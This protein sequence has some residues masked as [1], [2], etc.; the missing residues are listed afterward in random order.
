MPPSAFSPWQRLRS[1]AKPLTFAV[2]C[3]ANAE[4]RLKIRRGTLPHCVELA[5]IRCVN[6]KYQFPSARAYKRFQSVFL[7]KSQA[8]TYFAGINL[9]VS[10]RWICGFVHDAY[11]TSIA[12]VSNGEPKKFQS[13][14]EKMI[15]TA[16]GIAD[17]SD[18]RVKLGKRIST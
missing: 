18:K 13:G 2:K 12:K 14:V 10:I 9:I 16:S 15:Q 6:V 7:E 3:Y 1:T 5:H 8:I 4:R 11:V 17:V